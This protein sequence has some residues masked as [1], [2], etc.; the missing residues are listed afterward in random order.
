MHNLG[1]KSQ[2]QL[3]SYGVHHQ[4]GKT[5]QSP[6]LMWQG[7]EVSAAVIDREP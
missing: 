5:K 7:M 1:I 3:S 2:G 6:A 4:A